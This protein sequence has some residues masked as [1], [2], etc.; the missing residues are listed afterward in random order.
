MIMTMRRG[1]QVCKVSVVLL[2]AVASAISDGSDASMREVRDEDCSMLQ[3]RSEASRHSLQGSA[4]DQ[5]TATAR[6]TSDL[7][8]DYESFTMPALM[9]KHWCQ[10]KGSM[11]GA[12]QETTELPD[13][14]RV[15][16]GCLLPDPAN[17]QK[18]FW[19]NACSMNNND[20]IL[21][22]VN[23]LAN[24]PRYESARKGDII[25][26]SCGDVYCPAPTVMDCYSYPG[27]CD[28]ETEFCWRPEHGGPRGVASYEPDYCSDIEDSMKNVITIDGKS[29]DIETSNVENSTARICSSAAN[30]KK[31]LRRPVQ[32]QCVKYRR[33]GQSCVDQ[34][35]TFPNP[36]LNPELLV[37]QSDGMPFERPFVCAPDL[38]CTGPKY[39][40][41]PNTCVRKRPRDTCYGS[42]SWDSTECP[43]NITQTDFGVESGL[44]WGEA[45]NALRTTLLS[46]PAEVAS[47]MSCQYWDNTTAQGKEAAEIRK[48]LWELFG[49]LWPS[50]T[51]PAQ[52]PYETF[53][54]KHVPDPFLC[55]GISTGAQCRKAAMEQGDAPNCVQE[56][57]ILA[58]DFQ[59]RP[60]KIW[61]VIHFYM[62]NLVEPVTADVAYAAQALAAFL[63]QKF[64]SPVDRGFFQAGVI[65]KIGLPPTSANREDIAKW[66]W[67]AHN[68]VSEHAAATRGVQPWLTIKMPDPNKSPSTKQNDWFMPWDTAVQQ[69]TASW[70]LETFASSY[71]NGIVIE[72]DLAFVGISHGDCLD[73]CLMSARCGGYNIGGNSYEEQVCTLLE[74]PLVVQNNATYT[75]YY[76]V[77]RSLR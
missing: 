57:L 5:Y 20:G 38:V 27:I 42:A 48:R 37:R 32:A 43:R 25:A 49:I 53:S 75:C 52:A 17:P 71:C 9:K 67:Y 63:G 24:P 28:S 56:A 7:P 60:C 31:S 14:S 2:A 68:I 26:L 4:R 47:P 3:A 59:S 77:K 64:T 41:M 8:Q 12:A 33:E 36:S 62:H 19:G 1:T 51:L 69:W 35:L 66:Y 45:I 40:V 13:G 76:V 46:Y 23:S 22:Y 16:A 70:R 18:I 54:T 10:W 21:Y 61:S 30:G 6:G 34:P 44:V 15:A 55:P 39:H 58:R 73:H 72:D 50:R 65:G 11:T 29:N 74:N